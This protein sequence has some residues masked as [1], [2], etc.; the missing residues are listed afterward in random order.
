MKKM[1]NSSKIRIIATLSLITMVATSFAQTFVWWEG[2]DTLENNFPKNTWFAPNS[3]AEKDLLSGGQW[4]TNNDKRTGD[5]AFAIYSVDL[6]ADGQY[7]FWTRKFWKHGPFK[8]RFDS[9]EWQICGK[10]IALADNTTLR[11]HVTASWVFLG[12]ISLKKGTHKF[13]IR[14]LAKEGESLT[15]C[16][17]CF[18]LSQKPFEPN[19]KMKPGQKSGEADDGFFAWEP[20]VDPFSKEALLD[21]RYLNETTAGQGGH[22]VHN[23]NDFTLGNGKSVRFWGANVS[24][25]NAGQDR[26]SI[27]FMARKLAKL[28]VNMVRFHSAMFE[29]SGDPA[30]VDKKKLDNLHYL[31]SAMKREGIYTKISFYFPLWF[32]IKADYGIDGFE[33][34]RIRFPSPCST[35]IHACR[36]YTNHGPRRLS[37][38]RTPTQERL[39]PQTPPWQLLRS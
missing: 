37:Q 24:A 8:W 32:N 13:E 38:P 2:E 29:K 12:N 18:I 15:A 11:T 4:L 25:N 9:E 27:D 39:L 34:N 35:L 7:G 26:A 3:Q 21:L 6:P 16:F 36:R 28:G 22:I 17:D 20:S 1:T 33:S 31:I 10:D 14:L 30:L 19:G 5:E 23:G